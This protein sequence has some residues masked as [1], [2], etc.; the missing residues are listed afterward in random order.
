MKAAHF[1]CMKC[2]NGIDAD[3]NDYIFSGFWPGSAT[4]TAISYL[5][6]EELLLTWYHLRHKSPLNSENMFV[7]TIEEISKEFGRV[8]VE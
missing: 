1:V 7:S 3:K 6:S 8:C 5:F 4:S 2:K